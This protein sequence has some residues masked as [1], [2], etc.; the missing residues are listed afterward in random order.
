MEVSTE[1]MEKALAWLISEA[2]EQIRTDHKTG[3]GFS[4]FERSRMRTKAGSSITALD[5]L[6]SFG[7]DHGQTVG[8]YRVVSNKGNGKY[9]DSFTFFLL[10]NTIQTPEI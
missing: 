10:E 3:G 1:R 6:R 5:W 9:P 7:F 2:G 4:V 8:K